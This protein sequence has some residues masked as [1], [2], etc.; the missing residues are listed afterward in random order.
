M[1]SQ[2]VGSSLSTAIVVNIDLRLN[3]RRTTTGVKLD[4]ASLLKGK[5]RAR[6][7]IAVI[8]ILSSSAVQRIT[9]LSDHF[10]EA[11]MFP[12]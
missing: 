5:A 1:R 12:L 7:S 2:N 8:I 4:V 10:F 6:H 9:Y 11:I 3:I